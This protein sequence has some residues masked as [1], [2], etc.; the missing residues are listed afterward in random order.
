L[1]AAAVVGI[2]DMRTVFL[3]AAVL[4]GL[5]A[6]WVGTMVHTPA[7]KPVRLH[8]EQPA[9]QQVERPPAPAEHAGGRERELASQ[10]TG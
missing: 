7:R 8:T 6:L 2:A 10:E 9:E 3:T 4:L 5:I 1:T